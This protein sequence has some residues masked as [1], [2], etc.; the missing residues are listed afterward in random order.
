M[1]LDK[2]GPFNDPIRVIGPEKTGAS[3]TNPQAIGCHE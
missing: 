3:T 1:F 2:L